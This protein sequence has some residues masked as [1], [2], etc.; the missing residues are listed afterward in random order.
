[1]LQNLSSAAV[2]SLAA[3]GDKILS[4]VKS[5]NPLKMSFSLPNY[6]LWVFKKTALPDSSSWYQQ[7]MF[8]V[9]NKK[10]HSEIKLFK[11]F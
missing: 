8:L 3:N 11:A 1:M 6:M 9:E 10:I 7:P 2:N 5:A 4:D